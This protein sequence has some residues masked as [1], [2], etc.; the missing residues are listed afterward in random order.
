MASTSEYTEESYAM[1][2][3]GYAWLWVLVTT[4]EKFSVALDYRPL[5]QCCTF[6]YS[7]D[8]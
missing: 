1:L 7:A 6:I 3:I 8:I 4:P 2:A 5:S